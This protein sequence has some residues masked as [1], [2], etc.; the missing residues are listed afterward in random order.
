[1]LKIA[2]FGRNTALDAKIPKKV[3]DELKIKRALTRGSFYSY[4]GAGSNCILNT[5]FY[6]NSY[7]EPTTG[8]HVN[9]PQ[10]MGEFVLDKLHGFYTSKDDSLINIESMVKW[11][12]MTYK[13][14]E[15][16]KHINTI[17]SYHSPYHQFSIANPKKYIPITISSKY[18]YLNENAR[19]VAN[20]EKFKGHL[21]ILNE[22]G[23]PITEE[24]KAWLFE[25]P[26]GYTKWQKEKYNAIHIEKESGKIQ[27][28]KNV[29]TLEDFF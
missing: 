4:I 26:E 10:L 9:P 5:G 24:E 21:N 2:L 11:V 18:Q 8:D 15:V 17:L 20:A 28:M 16:S 19:G 12:K 25:E 7:G 6:T 27:F 13:T 22:C 3:I 1:M 23:D 14:V 29:A